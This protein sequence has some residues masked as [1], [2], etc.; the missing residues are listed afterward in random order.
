MNRSPGG[1]HWLRLKLEGTRSNRS[2][3]GARAVA[4]HGER[5][6]SRE[7]TT[8]AGYLSGQSLFLHFGLGQDASADRLAIHWPSGLLQE[9]KD[10][11][12][13]EFYRIVEGE[14]LAPMFPGKRPEP[15]P[16]AQ[17]APAQAAGAR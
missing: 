1:G 7:V 5:R 14:P 16:T 8:T 3:I 9:F 2:A 17:A 4:Y 10:V 13:D 11:P 6:E 15:P 12:A